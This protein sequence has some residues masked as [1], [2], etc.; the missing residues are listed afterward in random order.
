MN[1]LLDNRSISDFLN[2]FTLIAFVIAPP[3]PKEKSLVKFQIFFLAPILSIT[4]FP[5]SEK[6]KK[7]L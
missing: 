6:K 4:H 2:K 1:A 5:V 3:T 7:K